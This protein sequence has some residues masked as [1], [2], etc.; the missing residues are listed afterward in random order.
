[1]SDD[2]SVAAGTFVAFDR[3]T[4]AA[5]RASTPLTLTEDD[6]A[7]LRGIDDELDLDE[8]VDVYLPL[9]RLLNLNVTASQCPRAHL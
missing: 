6:L 8:V 5:L 2:H 3:E 9:S 4:W 7:G 1:M